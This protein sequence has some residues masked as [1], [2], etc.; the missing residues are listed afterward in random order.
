MTTVDA[1]SASAAT[2]PPPAT[3]PRTTLPPRPEGRRPRQPRQLTLLRLTDVVPL[4][5]AFFA[6]LSTAG[7]LWQEI[8]PFSGIIGFAIVTWCLFVL[9]YAMLVSFNEDRQSVRDKLSSVIVHSLA[10]LVVSALVWVIVFTFWRAEPALAHLNFYTQ[11]AKL[12]GPTSPLADGGALHAVVG[13]LI[14]LGI[15]LGIAVP[16]GV[17]AAVFMNE[18]PGPYARF[19]RTVV[20]AMSAMPDV[21]AGLFIY[22]TLI[23]ILGLGLCGLAA[24]CALGITALPIIC[25]ATD[26]VI[27]LMPGGL[28]EASYALGA[29]QWRTVRLTLPT[30]RSGLATA[31]ILGAARAIGETAPVLLTSGETN[32]LTFHPTGGPMMSLPLMAFSSVEEAQP[33]EITR[34]F[35]AAALLLVLVVLLFALAR[36]VGGRGPGQLSAGQQRRRAA[37]SRR[38]LARIQRRGASRQLTWSTGSPGLAAAG[39][40]RE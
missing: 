6:A 35:G 20:D 32:Y 27:R 23:L 33:L 17:L 11:D 18:V 10:L 22:A 12:S 24:G 38:D 4:F 15:A 28:T 37:G 31:V 8:S 25:R 9:Y 39:G 34:G 14:E 36:W 19:V 3:L 13:T 40:V 1:G 2:T 29:S 7:V 5:G 26:V 21:L 30:V 16:L